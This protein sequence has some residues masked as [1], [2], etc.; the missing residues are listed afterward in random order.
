MHNLPSKT[1]KWLWAFICESVLGGGEGEYKPLS[2]PR[3]K[4]T[5][6]PDL[7]NYP[8]IRNYA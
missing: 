4:Q 1:Q 7:Q 5:R 2:N 6:S 3:L 8:E